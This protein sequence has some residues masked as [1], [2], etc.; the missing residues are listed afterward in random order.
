MIAINALL[1]LAVCMC[2]LLSTAQAQAPTRCSTIDGCCIE[3]VDC[4]VC[5]AP[6]NTNQRVRRN[7]K[8][9]SSSEVTAIAIAMNEMQVLSIEEGRAKY[10]MDFKPYDYFVVKHLAANQDTRGDM[11]HKSNAF[12]TWHGA[13]VL[14]FETSLLAIDPAIGAMPYVVFNTDKANTAL[15]PDL[16]GT[17]PGSGT[18]NAIEDGIGAGWQIGDMT[19]AI[20]TSTWAQYVDSAYMKFTGLTSTGKLRFNANQGSGVLRF[21]RDVTSFSAT[22]CSTADTFPFRAW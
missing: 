22:T 18:N 21:G 3:G 17:A 6:P 5:T 15:T 13:L 19:P 10:G 11:A 20:W 4:P 9:L 12:A 14:S 16:L 7:I 2:L 8:E 1:A